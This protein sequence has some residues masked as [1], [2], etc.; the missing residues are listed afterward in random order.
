[1]FL[2]HMKKYMV[3]SR[4]DIALARSRTMSADMTGDRNAHRLTLER[5]GETL[6]G[7]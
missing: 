5:V 6:I 7:A 4:G 3:K 2:L 1:M